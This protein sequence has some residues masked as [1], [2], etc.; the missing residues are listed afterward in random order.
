MSTISITNVLSELFSAPLRAVVNAESEYRKIWADWLESQLALITDPTDP[1]KFRTGFKAEEWLKTAPVV[2]VDGMINMAIT[3]RVAG[4]QEKSYGGSAGLSLGPIYGS[5][6]FGFVNRSTEESV[7]RANASFTLSN[8][9]KDITALLG[10]HK[11]N[12]ASPE[13]VQNAITALRADPPSLQ[14]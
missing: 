6:G 11:L 1:K 5:G 9:G 12:P 7:F 10:Q 3:M 13:Q 4:V 8:T 2:S 14:E